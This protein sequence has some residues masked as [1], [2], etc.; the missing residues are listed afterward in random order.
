LEINKGP[1]WN[2]TQWV[3]GATGFFVS[4]AVAHLLVAQGYATKN[5]ATILIGIGLC[6]PPA[7]V[8]WLAARKRKGM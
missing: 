4:A 7:I 1:D 6:V 5:W 8:G 3:A 2:P